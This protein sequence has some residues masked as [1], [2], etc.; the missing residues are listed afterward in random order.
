MGANQQTSVP[1]FTAGQVLTA[2]QQTEINTG[3]PVFADATARNAAFG[4]AGEKT[5]AEGQLAY[6][7]DLDV[8]QF[9]DGAAWAT[10]GPQTLS[11]GL[12]YITGA[13]FTTATSV[14]LPD[15][16]FTSTYD[17]YKIIWRITGGTA[18]TPNITGRL[19]A[20]GSDNTNSSY[21]NMNVGINNGAGAD[22]VGNTT[23]SFNYG[24]AAPDLQRWSLDM[25]LLGPKTATYTVAI[26][27]LLALTGTGGGEYS[28]RNIVQ[29]FAANTAFDSFSIIASVASSITGYYK[30]Y[31]Y[32][33]S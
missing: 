5:L 10:V 20:A 9:Y 4:G 25:D 21:S 18:T 24:A 12:N 6:L 26:G 14:S 31:G 33:N 3:V 22:S 19:R 15:D 27:G 30:I 2:Q 23:T 13:S 32:A 28:G 29:V 1:A 11:S 8:V 7:E 17:N 16:T